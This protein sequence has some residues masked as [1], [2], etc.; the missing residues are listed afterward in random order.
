ME[1]SR[2]KHNFFRVCSLVLAFMLTFTNMPAVAYATDGFSTDLEEAVAPAESETDAVTED[3][4]TDESEPAVPDE[5]LPA[6]DADPADGTGED[7]LDGNMEL[8]DVDEEENLLKDDP[9]Q[10]Y[11][12]MNFYENE[13]AQ[14][15]KVSVHVDVNDTILASSIPTITPPGGS[16]FALWKSGDGKYYTNEQIAAKVFNEDCN[17]VAQYAVIPVA[18]FAEDGVQVVY[19]N[20]VTEPVLSLA[21]S[22]GYSKSFKSSNTEFATVDPATG[23]VTTCKVTATNTPV[24]ITA[25][26]TKDY[27]TYDNTVYKKQVA[28]ASYAELDVLK[29]KVFSGFFFRDIKFRHDFFDNSIV[30]Y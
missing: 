4:K 10:S 25:E 26:I 11:Y 15:P 1:I 6:E 30:I 13:S 28:S 21:P 9:V 19:G 12:V 14:N 29:S 2:K 24:V 22:E 20:N 16:L 27:T 23:E 18:S 5:E 3:S 8:F 17:F 7:E